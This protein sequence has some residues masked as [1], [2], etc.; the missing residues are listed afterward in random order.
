MVA[1]ITVNARHA[2]YGAGDAKRHM[3]AIYDLLCQI[4]RGEVPGVDS[5]TPIRD[6]RE[7]IDPFCWAYGYEYARAMPKSESEAFYKCWALV[8]DMAGDRAGEEI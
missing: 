3:E 2:C 4:G 1:S 5:N 6:I 7:H 8:L